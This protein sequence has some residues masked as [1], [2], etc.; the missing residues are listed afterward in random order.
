MSIGLLAAGCTATIGGTARPPANLTP[1][2][3][4]GQTIN[5]VLLGDES[6]SR[7]LNQSFKIDRRFPPQ[8]GGRETLQ[9]DGSA[10]PVDCLGVATMLHQSVYQSSNVKDVAVE[11]WRHAAMRAEVT[12]VKEGVVS[13]PTAADAHALFA[14]FS[15]QWQKCD[16]TT[17]PLPGGLFRLK[18]KTTNVQVATSVLA[19]TVS[20]T[21][22]LPRSESASIPEGRAIGVRDNCLVEVEVDFFNTPNPS[23]GE[24]ADINASAADVAHAMLDKVSALS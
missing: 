23:H 14:K 6:L 19:A 15:Q 11:T 18:A 16:G 4:A 5:Q 20:I 7:I 17:L 24:P 2:L 21:L 1:R 12:S 22:A 9:N 13:L 10:S 3:L 8:F